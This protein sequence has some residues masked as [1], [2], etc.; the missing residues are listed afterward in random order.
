[1]KGQKRIPEENTGGCETRGD[2]VDRVAEIA[3]RCGWRIRET[4]VVWL[5][6]KINMA[7]LVF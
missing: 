2:L 7:L 4:R 6:K 1:M 3:G 5:T